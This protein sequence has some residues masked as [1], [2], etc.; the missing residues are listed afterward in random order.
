MADAELTRI[1]MLFMESADFDASTFMQ[2]DLLH[3]LFTCLQK[4]SQRAMSKAQTILDEVKAACERLAGTAIFWPEA[5][6][7][8]RAEDTYAPPCYGGATDE[9]IK[10][11][12]NDLV[13]L[14]EVGMQTYDMF[15]ATRVVVK[16]FREVVDKIPDDDLHAVVEEL[17]ENGE[18]WPC[19]DEVDSW[20]DIGVFFVCFCSLVKCLWKCLKIVDQNHFLFL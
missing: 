1:L 17:D 13:Y 8:V 11:L 16:K 6:S 12:E 18:T 4:P 14:K 2:S 19:G 3:E 10:S 9:N 15:L 5:S 20:P 7:A